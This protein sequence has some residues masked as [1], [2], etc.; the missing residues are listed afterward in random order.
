MIDGSSAFE[1]I[2]TTDVALCIEVPEMYAI[3]ALIACIMLFSCTTKSLWLNEL[4]VCFQI[5][6]QGVNYFS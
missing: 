5:P 4:Q 6:T 3:D 2:N 1:G